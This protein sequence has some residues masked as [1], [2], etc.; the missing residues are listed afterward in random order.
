MDKGATKTTNQLTIRAII[1]T[2]IIP[3]NLHPTGIMFRN[4]TSICA[5]TVAEVG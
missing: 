5:D 1:P 3:V 2:F 4:S